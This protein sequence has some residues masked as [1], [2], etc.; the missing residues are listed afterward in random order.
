MRFQNPEWLM[1]LW[2][3]PAFWAVA[4]LSARRARKRLSLG[5]GTRMAPL[6]SK[7]TS[8]GR[9]RLKLILRTL[10]LVAAIFALARPQA[11]KGESEVKIRGV[12]MM[13][14]LDVST[15]MLAEDVKPSRLQFAKSE[16]TRL[17]DMLAG[18]KVGLVGFAGSA[19]LLSPLTSDL[20]SLKMFLD[21]LS[22]Y[23]VET[24]GTDFTRALQE[25]ADAFKRGG[26]EDDD[27]ARSTRV[28]LVLSDGEDQEK[29]A[30][31]LAKKLASDGYRIFT[32]AFGTERG[33]LIPMRDERGYLRGYK[34]DK[35][36]KEV[37]SQVKGEFLKE[38]A[39]VGQGAFHFATF[40]GNQAG[41]IKADIDRLQKAEFASSVSVQYE[42]RFQWF[43]YIALLFFVLELLVSEGGRKDRV[44]KGRFEAGLKSFATWWI[45]LVGLGAVGAIS[46]PRVAWAD[47]FAGVRQNNAAVRQYGEER[48]VEALD[49]FT[50]ALTDLPDRAEVH[51]NIGTAFMANKDD[52]KALTEFDVA[53]RSAPSTDLQYKIHF[54]RAQIFATAKKTPEA[55]DSYQ[56]ALKIRPDSIEVKT[57]IELLMAGGE[58]EG[59]GDD[60]SEKNDQNQ[61]QDQKQQDQKQ[62]PKDGQDDK[63]KGPPPK[64][65][66][67]PFKSEQLSPQD[68]GRILEELKRQEDQIRERMQREG[69]KD[70]PREKDW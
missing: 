55:L 69:A 33:G 30:L 16:L 36:G 37:N 32:V 26:L 47:E 41:A 4:I 38:L 2:L 66:P 63:Q 56:K 42:E 27:Q 54:N 7:Q 62:D 51:Y 11:G 67:Q 68:V 15:S 8:P 24:Q 70:S 65:T 40:G 49:G 61:G 22:P 46:S 44:W 6:L 58:G 52:E 10:G 21:S 3:I 45:F 29:G 17:F 50:Q 18:D 25:T 9:R 23:S 35:A 13:V 34:K 59:E 43:L 48:Y 39:Q 19:V 60:Q 64:P 57:N 20:S 1:L 31:D 28:I 53:L 5:L 14:M 12:E